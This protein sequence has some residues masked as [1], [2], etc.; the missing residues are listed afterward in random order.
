M[1]AVLVKVPK[2]NHKQGVKGAEEDNLCPLK[3]SDVRR[4][5]AGLILLDQIP[6]FDRKRLLKPP[7]TPG[8][9]PPPP[10]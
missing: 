9:Q 2:R 6:A 5:E 7:T 10:P 3:G 1:H 4:P 8:I